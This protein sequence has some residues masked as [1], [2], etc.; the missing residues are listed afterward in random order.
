MLLHAC[1]HACKRC[2]AA[3]APSNC[4]RVESRHC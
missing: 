3:D 1:M 2:G 4:M